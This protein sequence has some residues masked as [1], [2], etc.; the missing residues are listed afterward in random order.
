MWE[1]QGIEEV[2]LPGGRVGRGHAF[3]LPDRYAFAVARQ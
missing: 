3:Y 2:L 1:L